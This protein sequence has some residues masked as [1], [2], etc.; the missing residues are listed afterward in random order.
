MCRVIHA[1]LQ[2]HEERALCGLVSMALQLVNLRVLDRE[3]NTYEEFDD[4]RHGTVVSY[5]LFLTGSMLCS[6][7]D[8]CLGS[9]M[10][11]K[12]VIVLHVNLELLLPLNE[13]GVCTSNNLIST[14]TAPLASR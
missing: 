8:E 6:N 14:P 7:V 5:N 11:E 12:F 4:D 2:Q 9:T 10:Y 13:N 1:V 3:H